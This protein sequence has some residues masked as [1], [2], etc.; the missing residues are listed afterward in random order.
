MTGL[1]ATSVLP[2]AD[3]SSAVSNLDFLGPPKP[4]EIC[5]CVLCIC[6][7]ESSVGPMRLPYSPKPHC[8]PLPQLQAL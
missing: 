6:V 3:N 1:A 7:G 8:H 2:V 4:V 5:E